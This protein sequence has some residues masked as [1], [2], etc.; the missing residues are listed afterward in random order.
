MQ[1]FLSDVSFCN[2]FDVLVA[3]EIFILILTCSDLALWFTI[4][5]SWIFRVAFLLFYNSLGAFLASV[6]VCSQIR[7]LSRVSLK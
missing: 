1:A 7:C 2:L 5:S 3:L 6:L 4:T